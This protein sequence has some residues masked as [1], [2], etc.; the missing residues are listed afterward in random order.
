[1]PTA[2]LISG[3]VLAGGH[4]RRLGGINKALLDIAG[5]TNI[6]RVLAVL[7]PICGDLTVVVN[8][9]S[10]SGIPGV[11]LVLD[12]DPHAGVLPALAQGLEAADG[13]LAIVVACDMPFLNRRLLAEELCRA[14]TV[15]VVIPFVDGRLEPMHAVY[16]CATVLHAIRAAL[17]VGER[18]MTSF[19]DRLRVE[20]IEA[21]EMRPFDPELRSFFNTNTPEDLERARAFA[22]NCPRR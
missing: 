2:E 12:T 16:R 11:R 18:R 3:V 21:A 17:A 22:A 13:T 20:R 4:G 6:A 5:S 7:E 10:L 14:T 15:D 8:D 1:M 9:A 19:L